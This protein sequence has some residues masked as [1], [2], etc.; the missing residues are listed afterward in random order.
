MNDSEN[1]EPFEPPITML[2]EWL[3][4][5]ADTAM[6]FT[7]H[8][9]PRTSAGEALGPVVAD[10]A[11]FND[12]PIVVRTSR[13]HPS[14]PRATEVWDSMSQLKASYP[15][16]Y[17]VVM[18]PERALIRGMQDAL[19]ISGMAEIDDDAGAEGFA[20]GWNAAR[21]QVAQK[22]HHRLR[23]YYWGGSN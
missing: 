12:G 9:P 7:V 16:D 14:G 4:Y 8:R 1:D 20:R 15:G 18:V 22:I 6:P 11:A 13:L 19:S 17:R 23:R 5:F 10:G 3:D 21:R 2:V